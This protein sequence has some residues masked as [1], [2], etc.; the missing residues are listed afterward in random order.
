MAPIS[1][2]VKARKVRQ[3]DHCPIDL[4]SDALL[5]SH[6]SFCYLHACLLA[7]PEQAKSGRTLVFALSPSLLEMLLGAHL[8]FATSLSSVLAFRPQNTPGTH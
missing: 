3:M 6:H 4:W 8:V 5:L 7:I 2:R 1:H